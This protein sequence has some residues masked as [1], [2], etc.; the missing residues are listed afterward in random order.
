MNIFYGI[1]SFLSGVFLILGYN[2]HVWLLVI[3]STYQGS[4]LPY[5]WPAIVTF[6]TTFTLFWITDDT[7]VIWHGADEYRNDGEKVTH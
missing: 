5:F 7:E 2:A 4:L 6:A 1:I 3:S